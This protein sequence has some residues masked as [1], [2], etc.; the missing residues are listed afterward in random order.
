MT[1]SLFPFNSLYSPEI[2]DKKGNCSV[3]FS[4]H[5]CEPGTGAGGW[6]QPSMENRIESIKHETASPQKQLTR[7][8]I[9]KH[10]KENDC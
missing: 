9:E 3:L 2:L 5:P 7:E 6:M 10:N 4:R 8:E 1:S